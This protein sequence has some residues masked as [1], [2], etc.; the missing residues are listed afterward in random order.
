M[1]SSIKGIGVMVK[2][3]W[4]DTHSRLEDAYRCRK[5]QTR[6]VQC[7][8]CGEEKGVYYYLAG[9]AESP[10]EMIPV[11]QCPVCEREML[12]V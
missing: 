11:P 3:H 1:L 10:R 12:R 6:A 7:A 8:E 9:F 5:C 4:C 2:P